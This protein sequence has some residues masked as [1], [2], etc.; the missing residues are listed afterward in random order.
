MAAFDEAAGLNDGTGFAEQARFHLAELWMRTGQLGAAA[1][2]AQD[3]VTGA[4]GQDLAHTPC[5][6]GAIMCV[7]ADSIIGVW[8]R[9]AG[10]RV[11]ELGTPGAMRD[12]LNALVLAGHKTATAGLL[13]ED[14][15]AEAEALE[16]IGEQLVLLDNLGQPIALVEVDDVE[17]HPFASVSWAFADAEGEGFT[18][19]VDWRSGHQRYWHTTGRTVSETTPVVCLRFHV[20][21]R[22]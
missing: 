5:V 11:I 10:R 13:A 2:L 8:G 9:V 16:H 18:S 17:V 3:L 6:A 7:S 12:E 15:E 19:I 22:T 20:V 14:Y 1:T 4:D 21:P